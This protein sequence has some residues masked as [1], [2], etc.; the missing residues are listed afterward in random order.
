M[1]QQRF[2]LPAAYHDLRAN[3]HMKGGF[4]KQWQVLMRKLK[5][6]HH[7]FILVPLH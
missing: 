7:V 2:D 1:A 6:H 3:S 4:A 5:V